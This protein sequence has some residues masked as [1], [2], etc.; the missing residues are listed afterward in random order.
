MDPEI[1]RLA[2]IISDLS[3]RVDRLEQLAAAE[4]V[5]PPPRPQLVK[6]RPA[7]LEV[8]LGSQ[9]L[10]RAG[11][12]ALLVGI[13]FFLHWGVSENWIGPV[14]I[15][16]F[17]IAGGLALLLFGE[18][19]HCKQFRVFGFSLQGLGIAALYLTL[20]AA[21]QSYHLIPEMVAFAGM[22][23]LTA[24][25]AAAAILGNSETL[26]VFAAIG[27]FATPLLLSTGHN[28][29]G[30][31]FSYL[32][33]LCAGMLATIRFRGWNG[34]LLTSFVGALADSVAW[35]ANYYFHSEQAETLTFFVILFA[36]FAAAPPVI[37]HRRQAFDRR[38]PLAI[39][40]SATVMFVIGIFT[41][42]SDGDIT[43][44]GQIAAAGLAIVCWRWTSGELRAAYF[45]LAVA[46]SAITI[47]PAMDQHWGT[48][49]VWLAMGIVLMLFGLTKKIVFVRWI[50]LVLLGLTI[51]KVFVVDLSNLG[52]GYRILALSVLGIAL[53]SLSFLYQRDWLGLRKQ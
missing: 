14:A 51:L 33:I 39:A 40:I 29:E 46:T 13:A 43:L 52:E 3:R 9:Y 20:W 28:D 18:W 12:V 49:A 10:N 41:I 47:P 15:V 4:P 42:L 27:G 6:P 23:A 8:R 26:A 32:V 21:F 50:A 19:F 34:L 7:S 31:L 35:F 2:Q 53:L 25:T 44:G 37:V 38:I 5:P 11:I 17:G 36:I 1:E 22:A 30:Q 24:A 16:F 48:S 45:A